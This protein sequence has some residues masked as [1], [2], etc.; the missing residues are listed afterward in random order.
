[1]LE[2]TEALDENDDLGLLA[3]A[4]GGGDEDDGEAG[5]EGAGGGPAA[6]DSQKVGQ[7]SNQNLDNTQLSL[8]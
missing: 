4:G 2:A 7:K 5:A 6:A 3:G 1:M 8:V